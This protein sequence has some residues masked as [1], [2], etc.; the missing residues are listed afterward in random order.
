M[1]WLVLAIGIL[2]RHRSP[3]LNKR[4]TEEPDLSFQ[5]VALGCLAAED[6]TVR[7]IT[8]EELQTRIMQTGIL[9]PADDQLLERA[10]NSKLTQLP[11]IVTHCAINR[12]RT[13][14]TKIFGVEKPLIFSMTPVPM[15]VMNKVL[16]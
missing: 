12:T 7:P 2:A 15:A 3:E 10:A 4:M 16:C 14:F 1:L 9:S 13:G 6:P 5:Q 11:L 8:R